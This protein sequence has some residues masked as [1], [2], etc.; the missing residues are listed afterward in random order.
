[1][2]HVMVPIRRDVP[3]D[4]AWW[5]PYHEPC[6]SYQSPASTE[7]GRPED[8]RSRSGHIGKTRRREPVVPIEREVVIKYL[9]YKFCG[10]LCSMYG[11]FSK[12]NN[13][14]PK[15][16]SRVSFK[17]DFH[18][19]ISNDSFCR[20]RSI[21][22]RFYR[23]ININKIE[24]MLNNHVKRWIQFTDTVIWV[25]NTTEYTELIGSEVASKWFF[26]SWMTARMLPKQAHP[27]RPRRP[28]PLFV[29]KKLRRQFLSGSTRF[30][31][32]SINVFNFL[33]TSGT[34][35]C[36]TAIF[37]RYHEWYKFVQFPLT[38]IK[39]CLM[40]AASL[41]ILTNAIGSYV[42]I[43]NKTYMVAKFLPAHIFRVY[44][45]R[46]GAITGLGIISLR[47]ELAFKAI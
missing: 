7:L 26:H 15:K 33:L 44:L 24:F 47:S 5:L 11:F 28:R 8:R 16:C 40:F 13:K 46:C 43:Q 32:Q 2:S 31:K 42:R 6:V 27:G 1:M 18:I 4:V 9:R 30:A 21:K 38:S 36:L 20:C 14:P 35:S 17:R 23:H 25:T 41:S 19:G 39:C 29:S 12:W 3:C 34:L 37:F 45:T 10:I 22:M